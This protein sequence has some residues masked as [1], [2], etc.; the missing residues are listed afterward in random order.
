MKIPSSTGSQS[1]ELIGDLA[2]RH[3]EGKLYSQQLNITLF[4]PAVGF[5]GRTYKGKQLPMHIGL[6]QGELRCDETEW[7]L[8]YTQSE[9]VQTK[10]IIEILILETDSKK[11]IKKVHGAGYCI[12]PLFYEDIPV[13]LEVYKGTP[14]EVLKNSFDDAFQPP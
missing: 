14:R 8:F 13:T 1:V 3:T 10:A 2:K 6:D 4:N 7:V 11:G 9:A 12:A 5:F